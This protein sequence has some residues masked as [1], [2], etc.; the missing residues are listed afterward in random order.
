M[1]ILWILLISS[2]PQTAFDKANQIEKQVFEI[3][4]STTAIVQKIQTLDLSKNRIKI[5][6]GYEVGLDV[7]SS[8]CSEAMPCENLPQC[9]SFSPNGDGFPYDCNW[10][11]RCIRKEGHTGKHMYSFDENPHC[12]WR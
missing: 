1:K 9:G 5:I 4:D 3:F 2:L 10:N 12:R 7:G 8:F 11:K 6:Q